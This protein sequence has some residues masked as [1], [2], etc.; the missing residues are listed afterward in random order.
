MNLITLSQLIGMI[1]FG[2]KMRR[3]RPM[4]VWYVK[5]GDLHVYYSVD[6]SRIDATRTELVD[7][8]V[9]ISYV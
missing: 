8:E 1:L 2:L 3:G 4:R 5:Q 9:P 6:S 7:L